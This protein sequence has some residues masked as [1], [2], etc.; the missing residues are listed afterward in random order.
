MS[1]AVFSFDDGQRAIN[2]TVCQSILS[3]VQRDILGVNA[4]FLFE[5]LYR[6]LPALTVELLPCFRDHFTTC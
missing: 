2:S 4:T 3:H 5:H 1:E 6:R